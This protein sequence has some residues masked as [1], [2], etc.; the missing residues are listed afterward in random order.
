MRDYIKHRTLPYDAEVEWLE[1]TGTQWNDTGIRPAQDLSF[2]VK[3]DCLDSAFGFGNVFG[4]RLASGN[5]EYQV[6]L[7]SGGSVVVGVRY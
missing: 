5:N 3:F 2:V 7:Y 1:S 6:T 4:S